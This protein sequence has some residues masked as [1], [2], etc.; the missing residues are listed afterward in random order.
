VLFT[1]FFGAE[2]VWEVV[3]ACT[4][5]SVYDSS[6]IVYGDASVYYENLCLTTGQQYEF[7]I[8][9][10]EGDGICCGLFGDGFYAIYYED[11]YIGG[12]GAFFA[13][14]SLFFGPDCPGSTPSPTPAP[15]SCAT[16]ESLFKLELTT[17]A[18]GGETSW[19]LVNE[20]SGT[21][22]ASSGGYGN[23]RSYTEFAC[24]PS[25]ALYRFTIYDSIGDGMCCV[26]GAGSYEVSFDVVEASG[27]PFLFFESSFFGSCSVTPPVAPSPTPAPAPAPTCFAFLEDV[28]ARVANFFAG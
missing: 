22:A 28:V 8:Y 13:S 25:D 24:I 5:V 9:D 1:D 19:D 10:T 18:Y 7:I 11:T 26:W 23:L 21:T 20:C 17:D 3:D 14:E 2:T 4:G 27:G 12:G 6:S 16:G 15:P